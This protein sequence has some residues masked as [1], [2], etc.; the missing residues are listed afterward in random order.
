[1]AHSRNQ[2]NFCHTR[3]T[4][5]LTKS[6][7][8]DEQLLLERLIAHL[9]PFRVIQNDDSQIWQSTLAEAA[10]SYSIAAN[11]DMPRFSFSTIHGAQNATASQAWN[12]CQIGKIL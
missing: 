3:K 11:D 5:L 1:M 12:S 7:S 10:V 2:R 8:V 4:N 9:L 6:K